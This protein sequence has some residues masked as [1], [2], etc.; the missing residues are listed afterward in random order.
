MNVIHSHS[1]NSNYKLNDVFSTG[2]TEKSDSLFCL[3]EE[4]GTDYK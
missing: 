2:H 3:D 4:E 1:L